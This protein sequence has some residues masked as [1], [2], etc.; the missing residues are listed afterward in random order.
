MNPF[1]L[2]TNLVLQNKKDID[3][4]ILTLFALTLSVKPT[5]V[6]EL[7]VRTARSTLPFLYASQM[8]NSKVISVDV[9][10]PQPDFNFPDEWKEKWQFL[11]KDALEFLKNDFPI[12]RKTRNTIQQEAG[13][14]I[15]IDDWHA[16]DHVK[17]ELELI[18]DIVTPKDVIILHDLM[19]GNSQPHYRSV[20]NPT[21]KQWDKGGP[22]KPVSELDLSKWEYMTIP[23]CHG[24]TLLRKRSEKIITV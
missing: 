4:H 17:K 15:Y 16:G 8:I 2:M 19:Y 21:D 9:N 14:I 23:R 11:R 1:E 7:G 13:D 10:D 18:S 3:E 12:L 24:L 5:T 20:E 6:Y 22:Y